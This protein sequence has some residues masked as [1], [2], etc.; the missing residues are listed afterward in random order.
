M[1]DERPGP[2]EGIRVIDLSSVLM[3][4]SSTQ[5]LGDLGVFIQCHVAGVAFQH[6]FDIDP[7][8]GCHQRAADH[9]VRNGEKGTE[10]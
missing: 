7:G 6:G 4:P 9:T 10:G 1:S 2:L 3:G 5:Y 8:T